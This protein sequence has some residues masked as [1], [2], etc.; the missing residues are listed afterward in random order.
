MLLLLLPPLLA[1]LVIAADP[2]GPVISASVDLTVEG[3]TCEHCVADVKKALEA[4]SGVESATVS[5]EPGTAV[6]VGTAPGASLLE[7]VEGTGRAAN[8]MADPALPPAVSGVVQA[9][10][11]K[12]TNEERAGTGWGDGADTPENPAGGHFQRT[13]TDSLSLTSASDFG[14]FKPILRPFLTL[15]DSFWP[16]FGRFW[17]IHLTGLRSTVAQTRRLPRS[18]RARARLSTMRTSQRARIGRT[19][20][21][22]RVAKHFRSRSGF[23][24]RPSARCSFRRP[25]VT[26]RSAWACR[27]TPH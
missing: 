21:L 11:L 25:R 9:C 15:F 4:V 22:R 7:A 16:V 2:T 23:R 27:S 17:V 8:L 1:A 12:P 5:L 18:R 3:M 26:T 24:T 14:A 6:V 13:R 10:Y 19:A 20:T